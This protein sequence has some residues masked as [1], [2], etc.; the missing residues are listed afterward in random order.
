MYGKS[1]EYEP[2][3]LTEAAHDA[4]SRFERVQD[5]PTDEWPLF[6]TDH[7]AS[8]YK[9]VE[10]A[11]GDRPEPGSDIDSILREREIIP[12]SITKE[13]GRQI[14]KQLTDEA[15]IEVDGDTNY[16]QPHGA[17]RAL[18]AELYEKGHSELAQKAL[19]HE[20]I[21]TTHK[22]YSDIQAENGE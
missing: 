4:L 8:K 7:A 20:S 21:E 22:A 15:G 9:A 5:P 11:T 2:V 3:G 18:G 12:P 17:R 16:L 19:R 1:R 10:N 13:A 6:P 14:L